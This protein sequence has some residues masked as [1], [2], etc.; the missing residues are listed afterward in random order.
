MFVLPCNGKSSFMKNLSFRDFI[1]LLKTCGEL[2]AVA[3]EVDP[4]L[5]IAVITDRVCKSRQNRALLF[6]SVK[7]S[8]YRVATNLFG[9]GRRMSLALGIKELSTLTER[10]DKVL[11]D[12]PGTTAAEKLASLATAPD[13]TAAAPLPCPPLADL[14]EAALDLNRLP[15]IKNHPRDGQPLHDGRFL[16][17]PL[18]ITADPEGK[19]PNCGI[20]RAA[21]TAP[22]R[23]AIK[24]NSSSGA[25]QHAASWALAGKQMPVVIALGCSAAA[26]FAATLP[27]PPALDEFTFAG[28]LC[29]EALKVSRCGNGLIAPCDAEVIIEGYLEQESSDSGAFGNHSGFYT[30]SEPA[31]AMNVTAI[32]VR[33]DLILPATVVGQPPMEDCWF[34]RAGGCLLLSLLKI[35]VPAVVALHTPFAGIFHGAAFISL[36]NAQGKGLDLITAI[37]TTPWFATS[38]LLVIVDAEQD[39]ADEAAVFWRIMNNVNWAED[40][41]ISGEQLSIDATKKTSETRTVVASDAGMSEL[42]TKRWKEYGFDC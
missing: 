39:P 3:A 40:M 36:K 34:A 31:P 30:P 33:R 18:V 28:L 5:E 2:H 25:A 19:N 21:M 20:Y 14:H 6:D 42:V 1:D 4:E 7:G 22:D 23:L 32:R 13:W 38:R 17:L 12:L 8:S 35:D 24:W 10:F 26:T 15:I 41:I 11:A 27:L 29:G 16:T 37:R 9:S